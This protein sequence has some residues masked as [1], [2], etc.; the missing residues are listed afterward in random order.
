M[1][2]AVGVAPQA[3]GRPC[4]PMLPAAAWSGTAVSP[5]RAPRSTPLPLPA[6]S[7]KAGFDK[8]D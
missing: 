2:S 3:I 7:A 6:I 5:A 8:V 1:S 4:R